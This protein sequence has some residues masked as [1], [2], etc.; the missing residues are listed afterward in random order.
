MVAGAV[1]ILEINLDFLED[2]VAVLDVQDQLH[3]L[4]D[5]QQELQVVDPEQ[6]HQ[7]LDGVIQEVQRLVVV[8]LE[9]LEQAVAVLVLPEQTVEVL[10]VPHLQEVT[11]FHILFFH[12]HS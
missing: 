11:G 8:D 4:L 2:A 7:V 12:H 5:Q 9:D 10:M 3:K 1:L 6:L